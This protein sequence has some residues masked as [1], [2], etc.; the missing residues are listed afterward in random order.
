[1]AVGLVTPEVQN[2][3]DF[4]DPGGVSESFCFSI[5]V[6]DDLIVEIEAS[7]VQG[8]EVNILVED[9]EASENEMTVISPKRKRHKP[10]SFR[11]ASFGNML[12]SEGLPFLL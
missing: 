7:E 2:S 5:A 12:E 9:S 1:M 8:C 3:E 10:T 11:A 4:G 6:V